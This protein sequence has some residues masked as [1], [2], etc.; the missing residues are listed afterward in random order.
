[1]NGL[2]GV[3]RFFDELSRKD[4]RCGR[5]GVLPGD[6]ADETRPAS[7]QDDEHLGDLVVH[8][9]AVKDSAVAPPT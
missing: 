8:L 9:V 2:R 5:R 1:M 4:S 3:I 6:S 7:R